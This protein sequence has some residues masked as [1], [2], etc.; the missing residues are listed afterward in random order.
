MTMTRRAGKAESETVTVRATY[1]P[2]SH[3]HTVRTLEDPSV[4]ETGHWLFNVS[5]PDSLKTEE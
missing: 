1:E 3:P 4:S 2:T 5:A